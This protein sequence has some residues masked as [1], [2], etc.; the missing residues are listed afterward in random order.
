[1]WRKTPQTS[2]FPCNVRTDNE[3]VAIKAAGVPDTQIFPLQYDIIQVDSQ[4][5]TGAILKAHPDITNW[6][7]FGCTDS[8]VAGSLKALVAAGVKTEDIIGIGI[9]AYEACRPWAAGQ[10]TGFKGSLNIS[11]QDLGNMAA[12]ILNDAVVNGK[13]PPAVTI[14]LTTVIDA[15]NFKTKMDPGLLA[16]CGN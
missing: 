3:K 8:G 11:R 6:V 12:T 16:K 10:L 14:V 9:G 5:T 7:V 1:L 4:D 2:Q 15:T 13:P